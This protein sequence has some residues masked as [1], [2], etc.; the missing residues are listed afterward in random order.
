MKKL[1]L[2]K[3]L[4]KF[5]VFLP[6]VAVAVAKLIGSQ[7]KDE[8]L[9]RTFEI[10]YPHPIM[11]KHRETKAKVDNWVLVN[12]NQMQKKKQQWIGPI[13]DVDKLEKQFQID[14]ENKVFIFFQRTVL[15]RSSRYNKVE[16][17][18]AHGNYDAVEGIF[19]DFQI[20]E[21]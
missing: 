20:A 19:R 14:L 11:K 8:I 18:T 10:D 5:D 12:N 7:F 17:G 2:L 21:V 1:N 15:V 13:S 3:Q 9:T 16:H 6:K 4:I